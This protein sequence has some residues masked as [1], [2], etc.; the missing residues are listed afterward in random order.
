MSELFPHAQ[1]LRTKNCLFVMMPSMLPAASTILQLRSTRGS[2]ALWLRNSHGG[3]LQVACE[4]YI[5]TP[6]PIASELHS[7]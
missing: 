6:D 7:C 4:V 3:A 5:R 2:D 1:V